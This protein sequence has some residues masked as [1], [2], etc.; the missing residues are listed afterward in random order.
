MVAGLLGGTETFRKLYPL[1][2]ELYLTQAFESLDPAA[3][4][5]ALVTKAIQR[6]A[7]AGANAIQR[8]A[9]AGANA[10]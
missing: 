5:I 10:P 8:R 4:I 6:R 3:V 9:Q 1:G 7:Q 2:W